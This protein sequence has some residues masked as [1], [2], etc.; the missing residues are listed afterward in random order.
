[1]CITDRIDLAEVAPK[2]SSAA[3]AS[4]T[5]AVQ[6]TLIEGRAHDKGGELVCKDRPS[7][8]ASDVLVGAA[9]C[10]PR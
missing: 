4:L 8:A 5:M 10:L 3:P 6:D 2:F 1:M 9:R 7:Y